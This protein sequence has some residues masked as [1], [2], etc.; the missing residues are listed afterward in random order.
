MGETEAGFK[1]KASLGYLSR[2]C[3]KKENKKFD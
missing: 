1:F 3:L 2:H